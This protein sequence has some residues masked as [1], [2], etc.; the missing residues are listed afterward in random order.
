MGSNARPSGVDRDNAPE[1]VHADD[2]SLPFALVMHRK[3]REPQ[4]SPDLREPGADALGTPP[5]PDD[6][7][8]SL[9]VLAK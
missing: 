4:V 8:G 9:V 6:E 7:P 3:R 5:P 2:R 1:Y